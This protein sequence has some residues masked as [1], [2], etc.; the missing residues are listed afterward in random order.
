MKYLIDKYSQYGMKPWGSIK[1]GH[2]ARN[3]EEKKEKKNRNIAYFGVFLINKEM[4]Y[5]ETLW[6]LDTMLLKLY[7]PPLT[8]DPL[9]KC[10]YW[11]LEMQLVWTEICHKHKDHTEFWRLSKKER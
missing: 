5:N 2:T 11:V 8:L 4:Y 1:P 6:I 7:R 3:K 9:T 10:G